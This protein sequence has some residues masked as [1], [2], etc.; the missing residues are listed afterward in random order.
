MEGNVRAKARSPLTWRLG[1]AATPNTA[2]TAARFYR[3]P[4]ATKLQKANHVPVN[5]AIRFN[6]PV[7]APTTRL[8]PV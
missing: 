6:G 2:S 7:T 3:L 4:T 8:R 1:A 5:Y